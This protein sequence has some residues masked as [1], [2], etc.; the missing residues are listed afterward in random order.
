M[1]N[2]LIGMVFSVYFNQDGMKCEAG[3]LTLTIFAEQ[4]LFLSFFC[5]SAWAQ[6]FDMSDV[7]NN[8]R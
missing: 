3:I 7:R 2:G 5:C 6:E 1:Q 4:F 8:R